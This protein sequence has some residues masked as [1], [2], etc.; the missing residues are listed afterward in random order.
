MNAIADAHPLLPA[1]VRQRTVAWTLREPS[2][3]ATCWTAGDDGEGDAG[4]EYR[5]KTVLPSQSR[6]PRRRPRFRSR[7]RNKR[8]P[9]KRPIFAIEVCRTVGSIF[10][11]IKM[12]EY[13]SRHSRFSRF[14]SRLSRTNS[15]FGLLREFDRKGLIWRAV[16]LTE[17]RLRGQNRKNSRLNGKNRERGAGGQRIA[18]VI[19]MPSAFLPALPLK[20]HPSFL[21]HYRV[22]DGFRLVHPAGEQPGNDCTNDWRQP[23]QPELGDI[24]TAG[25]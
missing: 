15:R 1:S 16:F 14:N 21:H 20:G 8:T 4:H 9:H 18:P 13:Y 10:L 19:A 6:V 22:D 5:A 7:H 3:E 23:E 25:K 12:D 17:W 24:L 2:G 11:L